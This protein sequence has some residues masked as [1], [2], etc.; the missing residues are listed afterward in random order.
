MIQW[1]QAYLPLQA[2]QVL[3]YKHFRADSSSRYIDGSG[4]S[5]LH[6]KEGAG[7]EGENV[8]AFEPYV[9]AR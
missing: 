5:T 3:A 1:Q 8:R 6:R 4:G 7:G 2:V 9:L